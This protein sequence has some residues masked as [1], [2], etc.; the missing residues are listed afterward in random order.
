M[1]KL[2]VIA[3]VN[4]P[5]PWCH[6]MVV[7]R[8]PNGKLRVCID[9]RTI[10]PYVQHEE[11]P[12]PNIVNMPLDLDKARVISLLDLEAG[13]W[14]VPVY[15]ESAKLL[16]FSTPWGRNEYRRM[17]F[18]LAMAPEIFHKAVLEAVGDI[19]GVEVYIDNIFVHGENDNEH[20]E[21]LDTVVRR[22][23]EPLFTVNRDKCQL[24][25]KKIKFL[26]HI[27]G[28]GKI[29][30]NLD[31]VRALVEAPEPTCRND[32][33]SFIGALG[34]LRKFIPNLHDLLNDYRHL[35]KER[36]PWA[37]GEKEQR[38]FQKIKDALKALPPLMTLR[39]GEPVT[40]S[41]DTS[42]YGLGAC[43]TQV[44]ANEQE[45]PVFS[46]RDS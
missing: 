24:K 2:G 31:K 11:F 40:L 19:P 32:L 29:E 43:L 27:V 16:T 39:Q 9:P 5:R 26:G 4:E 12:L 17:P 20:D 7:T 35:M 13:F 3:P 22:L 1:E 36:T 33:K 8:K 28:G 46:P 45:R 34:W 21:R 10:N 41:T 23:E 44:D 6:A 42:S 30:P 18:G 25:R 15:D 37:W 38:T 14:Q